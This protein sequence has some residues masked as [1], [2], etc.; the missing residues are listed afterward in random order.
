MGNPG[1]TGSLANFS[2]D[3]KKLYIP[4]GDERIQLIKRNKM[5]PWGKKS[6]AIKKKGLGGILKSHR[7]PRRRSKKT[8]D[9]GGNESRPHWD[10]PNWGPW[11]RKRPKPV[12]GFPPTPVAFAGGKRGSQRRE[13]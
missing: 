1:E 5:K 4:K 11:V 8:V 10:L 7:T 2:R 3:F 6:F 13:V 12:D 9:E